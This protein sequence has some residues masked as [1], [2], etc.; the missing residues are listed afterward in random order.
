M[1][2]TPS[3]L[4]G[5]LAVGVGVAEG[6]DDGSGEVCNGEPDEDC[7]GGSDATLGSSSVVVEIIVVLPVVEV[8]NGMLV[9][10]VLS[11]WPGP[12]GIHRKAQLLIT[13]V[14]TSLVGQSKVT[15]YV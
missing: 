12:E 15:D 9:T 3:T 5:G 4:L 6:C 2:R 1:T 13:T 14:Y 11:A 7:D 10:P 8:G